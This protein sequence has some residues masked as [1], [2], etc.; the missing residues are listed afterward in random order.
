MLMQSLLQAAMPRALSGRRRRRQSVLRRSQPMWALLQYRRRVPAQRA[1]TA[2]QARIQMT[3][4][5]LVQIQQSSVL[6]SVLSPGQTAVVIKGKP[7]QTVLETKQ[8]EV[9]TRSQHRSS[10]A[11]LLAALRQT[12]R[13]RQQGALRFIWA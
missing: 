12:L 5:R 8:V 3:G 4:S 1:W 13:L 11:V 6:Q 7:A 10:T 2:R 9:L